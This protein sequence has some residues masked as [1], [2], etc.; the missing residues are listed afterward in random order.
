[1]VLFSVMGVFGCFLW[2]YFFFV[3]L[4]GAFLTFAQMHVPNIK[5]FLS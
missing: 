2:V 5:G 4:Q 3:V 1:M